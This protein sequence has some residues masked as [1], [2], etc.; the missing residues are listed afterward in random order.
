MKDYYKWCK[1]KTRVNDLSI[2]KHYKIRDVW[3]CS[4]GLNVGFEQDG[5]GI[6]YQRPV[7]ILKGISKEIC[8]VAPMTTSE[9]ASKYR[10]CAGIFSGKKSKVI[11]SQVKVVDTSRL[12]NKIGVVDIRIFYEIKKAVRN[13][14]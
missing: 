8:L 5:K 3:W 11:I 2:R 13:M 14:F 6:Y 7:L 4:L 10:I 9:K 1:E 12:V